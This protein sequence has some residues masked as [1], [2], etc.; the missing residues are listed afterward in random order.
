MS[1]RNFFSLGI[2]IVCAVALLAGICMF[3]I[4]KAVSVTVALV[5]ICLSLVVGLVMA[6]P[7][8]IVGLIA[9]IGLLVL[10]PWTV[11]IILLVCSIGGS[12]GNLLMWSNQSRKK[13]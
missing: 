2:G 1:K 5:L 9:G 6:N 3:F 4:P 12:V 10:P 13:A 11:G 8:S 7:L